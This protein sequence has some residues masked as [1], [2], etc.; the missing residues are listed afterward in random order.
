MPFCRSIA[1][2]DHNQGRHTIGI[3]NCGTI[4]CLLFTI[5][6]NI[7][8]EKV[9]VPEKIYQAGEELVRFEVL[10]HLNFGIPKNVL[11]LVTRVV[12]YSLWYLAR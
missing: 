1:L 10:V 3:Q 6:Q 11:N 9:C 12:Q 7:R 5:K 4:S 8:A 2:Q